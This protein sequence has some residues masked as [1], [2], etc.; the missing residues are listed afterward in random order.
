[1][2]VNYGRPG[3]PGSNTFTKKPYWKGDVRY[4]NDKYGK[5]QIDIPW[6]NSQP[7]VQEYLKKNPHKNFT[8][9]NDVLGYAKWAKKSGYGLGDNDA[10]TK[11]AENTPKPEGDGGGGD[12][13]GI[14][15]E[16]TSAYRAN[17]KLLIRGKDSVP[18]QLNI[19]N[20]QIDKNDLTGGKDDV[21]DPIYMRD[22]KQM[23]IDKGDA[24]KM[25][26]KYKKLKKAARKGN[27]DSYTV[28]NGKIMVDPTKQGDYKAN[29]KIRKLTGVDKRST[30]SGLDSHWQE[31]AN[32]KYIK[33]HYS[34][35]SDLPDRP[36]APKMPSLKLPGGIERQ[37]VDK[38]S[39]LPG[40]IYDY[41]ASGDYNY[42]DKG[43]NPKNTMGGI[44]AMRKDYKADY[45]A[46]KKSLNNNL[47]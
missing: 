44:K 24:K 9:K 19:S 10:T 42:D 1:M 12:Y 6:Y 30:G 5:P 16:E 29:K 20:L 7:G 40:K 31:L 34:G 15:Y 11:P 43:Y 17:E 26:I 35:D 23:V 13:E 14:P 32:D 36:K 3:M 33:K 41:K 21:N 28:K 27:D 25:G 2:T 8:S 37:K 39:G 18:K 47:K 46:A 22:A 38:P 4:Y 45:K